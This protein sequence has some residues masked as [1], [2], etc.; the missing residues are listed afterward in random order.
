MKRQ[1]QPLT[2]IKRF[3]NWLLPRLFPG[4]MQEVDRMVGVFEDAYKRGG[5]LMPPQAIIQQLRENGQLLDMILRLR[6]AV[7]L[8][9]LGAANQVLYSDSDRR[10]AIQ[11]SRYMAFSDVN[12][13]RAV[14][15]WTDFGLGKRVTV[16]SAV[17]DTAVD[18]ELTAFFTKPENLPIIGQ[19][20]I[21]EISKDSLNEG[22]LLA[23]FWYSPMDGVATIRT[24][25]T[26]QIVVLWEDQATKKV[27]VL[28]L[29]STN[30]GEWY[31]R[32]W[33]ASDEAVERIVVTLPKGDNIKL[34]WQAADKNQV[35]NLNGRDVGA[36][37][38]IALWKVRNRINGRGVPQFYNGL[39]WADELNQF[40]GAR[41][42][43][44]QQAAAYAEKVIVKGGSR[45]INSLKDSLQSS[46]ATGNEW[47]ERNPSPAPASTWI[48]NEQ[49]TREWM[50]RDTGGGIGRKRR[51]LD[52]RATERKHGHTVTLDG[53]SRHDTRGPGNGQGNV[54]TLDC[55][56]RGV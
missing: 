14:A 51:E 1:T 39:P 50:N 21:Q 44:A 40:I 23:V 6:G 18:N 8:T 17:G 33:R 41:S 49:V 28:Y 35:V 55:A 7:A 22:E 4:H 54:I 31:Y 26:D 13:E 46:L 12:I 19:D 34:T 56:N 47:I 29:H 16:T 11:E 43:V 53:V 38:A 2:R 30:T 32:D 20:N 52:S 48:E 36:T 45:P 37:Q 25:P 42:A 24:I 27:P 10:R 9:G 15:L 5:L 3:Q